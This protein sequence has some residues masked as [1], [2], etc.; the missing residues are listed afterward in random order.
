MTKIIKVMKEKVKI[1]VRGTHFVYSAQAV[2]A[3]HSDKGSV[4]GIAGQ[5]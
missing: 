5:P 4:M 1:L 3:G 2:E